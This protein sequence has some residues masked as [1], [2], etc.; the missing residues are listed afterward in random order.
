M[1]KQVL[2]A[3]SIANHEIRLV[4][5]EFFN[6]RLNIIKTEQLAC[7]GMDGLRIIDPDKVIVAIRQVVE[8]ASVFIGTP[9]NAVLLSVPSYRY[10]RE[11]ITLAKTIDDPQRQI[12]LSDIQELYD[13]DRKSVV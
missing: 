8:S 10:K 11:T 2:A 6:S 3:L 5:G 9:I 13:Q 7:G 12:N 4:V 1:E